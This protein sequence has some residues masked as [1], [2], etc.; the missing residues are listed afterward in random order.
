MLCYSWGQD[1]NH[2]MTHEENKF[3]KRCAITYNILIIKPK[4]NPISC[5]RL[6]QLQ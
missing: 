1:S 6:F 4:M 3:L 2:T 5:L